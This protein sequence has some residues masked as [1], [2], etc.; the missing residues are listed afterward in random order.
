MIANIFKGGEQINRIIASEDFARAYCT[1][2]GYTYTMEEEPEREPTPAPPPD[3]TTL[4]R[5]QVTMMQENQEFLENCLLEMAE[6]VY[7]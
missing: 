7:A 2:N 4:L 1:E 3:E 5:A 6:E